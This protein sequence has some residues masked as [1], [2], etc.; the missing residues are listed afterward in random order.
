ML[1][2]FWSLGQKLG[3]AKDALLSGTRISEE[4]F[5][6]IASRIRAGDDPAL[7]LDD[8]YALA[9]ALSGTGEECLALARKYKAAGIDELALTF[10]GPQAKAEIAAMGA[11]LTGA[12]GSSG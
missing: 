7:I 12:R 2:R 3:S 8:R 9:F 1:P 5:S 4:E 10:S 11:A 6:I